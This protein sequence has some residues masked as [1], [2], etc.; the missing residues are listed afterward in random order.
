[1]KQKNIAGISIM[2]V[3]IAIGLVSVVLVALIG[4]VA[5]TQ[6]NTNSSKIRSEASRLVSEASEWI[7]LQR[8]SN[9][10]TFYPRTATSVWCFDNLN[11]NKGRVCNSNEA[12]PGKAFIR[13]V[14][15]TRDANPNIVRAEIYAYWTDGQ[16]RHE[17]R[18]STYFTN[19]RGQ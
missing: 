3:L 4:L 1:M 5:T 14:R 10:N 19:W 6:R 11:W 16:G 8:D 7:R 9:W 17:V 12:V 15:F 2:E 18:T 13:E